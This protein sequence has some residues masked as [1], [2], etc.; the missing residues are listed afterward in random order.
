MIPSQSTIASLLFKSHVLNMC[1]HYILVHIERTLI[2]LRVALFL[3]PLQALSQQQR[4]PLSSSID[5]RLPL[6]LNTVIEKVV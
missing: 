5:S 4:D 2:A 1:E 6:S 3:P